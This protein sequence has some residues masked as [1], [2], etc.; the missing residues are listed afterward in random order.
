MTM[1]F[2]NNLR[3]GDTVD[4]RGRRGVVFSQPRE[5]SAKAHVLFE[6]IDTP[7]YLPVL[8]L[9]LV[10]DGVP[11]DVPPCDGE[12]PK[13][14]AP[15]PTPKKTVTPASKMSDAE[16][17]ALAALTNVE[18]VLMAGDNASR[19][20]N[21]YGPMW[22]TGHGTMPAGTALENELYRRGLFK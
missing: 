16:L 13:V 8:E 3:K 17:I 21:G 2:C 6:G 10:V 14:D 5:R 20:L 7:R 11:E 15:I 18:A 12:P 22:A 19:A 1:P 9:R 4:H